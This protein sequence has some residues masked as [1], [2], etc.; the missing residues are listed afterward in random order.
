[1]QI[2]VHVLNFH[3]V[4]LQMLIHR[5]NHFVIDVHLVDIVVFPLLIVHIHSIVQK[6][7]KIRIKN[8]CQQFFIRTY[9]NHFVN[10]QPLLDVK[11]FPYPIPLNKLVGHYLINNHHSF[12][13]IMHINENEIDLLLQH[14]N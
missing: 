8:T 9:L 11:Y 14:S 2:Y 5:S 12:D 4:D 13:S 10:I 3:Q 7:Y 1:M 6:I